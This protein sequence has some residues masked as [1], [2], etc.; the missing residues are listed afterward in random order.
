MSLLSRAARRAASGYRWRF[1]AAVELAVFGALISAAI[2][3]IT[4]SGSALLLTH[5]GSEALPLVYLLLAAISIPIASCISAML[6]R[7]STVRICQVTCAASIGVCASLWAALVAGLPG[8]SQAICV[9]AYVLE[10]IFDTLFWLLVSD[11][12][13]TRE[14]K[15]HTPKLA[16]AFGTGGMCGGLA[17]TAVCAV[18]P[19]ATLLL[20]AVALLCLCFQQLT[21]IRS[22]LHPLGEAGGAEEEP[23]ILDALRS[24]FGV[25]RIFPIATAIAGG[26]LLMSALF[27]L[28][29]YLAMTVFS[30]SFTDEARLARF[31]ALIYAGQQAAELL[32]LALC[33]RYVI[34]RARPSVRNLVFPLTTVASLALLQAWWALPAAI[35]LNL[36]ANSISNAVFEPVKTLNYAALPFQALGPVRMLVEGVVY[37]IGI[38][39][40]GLGLLA[41]QAHVGP[42]DV[43][44]LA[45]GLSVLFF[46]VSLVVGVLFVPS[47]MRSLR[48]RTRAIY[49][50]V[51]WS[52]RFS[53][54]DVARLLSHADGAARQLGRDIARQLFP[55]LLSPSGAADQ[56]PSTVAPGPLRIGRTIP[57]L[58][59]FRLSGAHGSKTV[60][61]MDCHFCAFE[62]SATR[63]LAAKRGLAN[64]SSH[65]RKEAAQCLVGFGK[66]ALPILTEYLSSDRP[67]VA[68]AAILALGQIGGW[69]ARRELRKHLK[70]FYDRAKRNLAGLEALA[71]IGGNGAHPRS[72]LAARQA[73][74]DSNRLILRRVLAVKSALG[75]PRDV[76]L[77]QS[78]AQTSEIRVRSNAVEALASLPT[79]SFIRPILPL[80]EATPT[81]SE[82]AGEG[83]RV[84][85][86]MTDPLRA[87]WR[88][89]K[90][91]RWVRLLAAPLLATIDPDFKSPVEDVMLELVLFLKSVPLFQVLSFESI[92]RAAGDSEQIHV[93]AG[94]AI[95]VAGERIASVDVLRSGRIDLLL[96]ER[97]VESIG[98]GSLLGDLVLTG[99]EEHEVTAHAA[100]DCE[101][102][103][104]PAA[105]IV[106]L[107]AEEPRILQ[108]VLQHRNARRRELYRQLASLNRN[109]ASASAPPRRRKQALA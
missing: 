80:L 58:W 75:D 83:R 18:L 60:T 54:A 84:S 17:S 46:A 92:A 19:V 86:S 107:T 102:V 22:R 48:L 27:C 7:W 4:T 70:P 3:A 90:K 21:R 98:P 66:A 77:L 31:M 8:V 29:D 24:T 6:G 11:Y 94:R 40:S 1:S 105:M 67:E 25:I 82:R 43:L 36:N 55:E 16:M 93:T 35:L 87:I 10:I 73:L 12:L 71:V 68:E 100:T 106:D 13:P 28:Q 32:I 104:F 30:A 49:P 56:S 39:L 109:E 78:L 53:R 15:R 23:A 34:D 91:D 96:G 20:L 85:T 65:V 64:A 51:G 47:M 103:R 42:G 45:I 88:A 108:S 69:R 9:T 5:E 44:S 59:P 57:R 72:V 52:K 97:V 101:I 63:L 14:L 79:G 74:E 99:D 89:A 62:A 50:R 81:N 38:A 76:A 95:F 37:P 61:R 41:L 2:I 26:I 33:G